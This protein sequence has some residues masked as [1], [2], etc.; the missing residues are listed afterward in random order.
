MQAHTAMETNGSLDESISKK[1]TV[2][3]LK[4]VKSGKA[5]GN[6]F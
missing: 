5:A 3:A 1:E 4:S 6:I 2:E